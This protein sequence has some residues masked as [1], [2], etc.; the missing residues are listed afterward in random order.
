MYYVRSLIYIESV[1][2]SVFLQSFSTYKEALT[3]AVELERM[4]P[5]AV[6]IVEFNNV[7]PIE[8]LSE[9]YSKGLLN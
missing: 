4:Q 7:T 3:K 5:E 1:Q 2:S 9:M 8:Q 6:T